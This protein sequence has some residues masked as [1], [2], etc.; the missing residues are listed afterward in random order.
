[1]LNNN[2]LSNR[3]RKNLKAIK[4]Y[5][6]KNKLT[7]YRVFDWDMPEYPM[8][9]DRYENNIYVAEYKTKHPLND[10]DYQIWMD[11]SLK[12]IKEVFLVEDDHLFVK[13]RERQKGIAQYEKVAD[14]KQFEI[15][16]ENGLKFLVNMHDYLDTGLFLDHRPLRLEFAKLKPGTRF[17]NCFCYLG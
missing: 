10:F 5:I 7:C 17:L 13:R 8:C 14:T 4:A 15:V 11:E 2:P 3:I 12:A 16:H 9:I 1:M 6:Q